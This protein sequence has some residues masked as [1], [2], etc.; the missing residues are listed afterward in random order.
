MEVGLS[1]TVHRASEVQK[2]L[3]GAG[4]KDAESSSK[5]NLPSFRLAPSSNFVNDEL[6]GFQ[7]HGQ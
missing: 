1:Q 5:R 4:C 3:L 6:I 2:A 7:F